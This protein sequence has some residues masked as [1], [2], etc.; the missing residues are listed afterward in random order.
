MLYSITD[1]VKG[2]LYI[3]YQSFC[4]VV[5]IWD[6]PP[7]PPQPSAGELYIQGVERQ[8]GGAF[9]V[10]GPKSYDSKETLVLYIIYSLNILA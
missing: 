6:H 10:G 5:M 2:V 8:I 3:E 7:P 9:R 1:T 4:A